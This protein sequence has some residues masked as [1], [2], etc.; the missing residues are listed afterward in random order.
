[1]FEFEDAANSVEAQPHKEW[2]SFKLKPINGS[3]FQTE[4]LPNLLLLL[5]FSSSRFTKVKT[6]GVSLHAHRSHS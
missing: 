4:P 1:M 2:F 6:Y 3:E 5:E